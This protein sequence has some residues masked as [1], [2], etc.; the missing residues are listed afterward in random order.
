MENIVSLQAEKEK[1]E[2]KRKNLVA[3]TKDLV[4]YLKMRQGRREAE[5]YRT[6]K[7]ENPRLCKFV[8]GG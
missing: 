6:L 5:R 8:Y 4:D 1:L 2:E 3:P 7:A